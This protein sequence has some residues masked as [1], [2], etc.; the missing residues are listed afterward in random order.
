[1]LLAAFPCRHSERRHSRC[2]L[3]FVESEQCD[4]CGFRG[5]TWGLW[6]ALGAIEGLPAHWRDAVDGLDEDELLRRPIDKMWSIA[7]YVDHVREVLF[8]MR[9]LLETALTLLGSDLGASPAS[10]FDEELRRI[11]VATALDRI[12]TETDALRDRLAGSS[13]SEWGVTVK[14]D[15]RDVD[16]LWIARHA[17]HD[18]TH[19][20]YDV[21]R[22]RTA[23]STG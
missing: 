16:P 6:D 20:L 4:E 14:F 22:L 21:S 9:F 23:M 18:A 15:G 19:H 8:G 3:H 5:E 1:M 10:Q 2:K 11:E 13:T 12:E 7:E 17:V